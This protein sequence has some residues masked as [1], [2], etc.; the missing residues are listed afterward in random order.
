MA[1]FRTLVIS[2]GKSTQSAKSFVS[3][4]AF[5]RGKGFEKW[6]FAFSKCR[7]ES[8]CG[9]ISA[10]KGRAHDQ[11]KKAIRSTHHLDWLRLGRNLGRAKAGSAELT[12]QSRNSFPL[13]R[14]RFCTTLTASLGLPQAR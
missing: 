10:C 2:A 12:V 1:V 3:F 9:E 4:K 14:P 5:L 11:H 7:M 13:R 6:R 8:G